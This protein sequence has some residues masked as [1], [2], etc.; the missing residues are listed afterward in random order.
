MR[1]RCRGAMLL[2]ARAALLALLLTL[3]GP[4]PAEA[5]ASLSATS[6]A[7][8]EFVSDEYF[9]STQLTI[10]N[11][12]TPV[13]YFEDQNVGGNVFFDRVEV[14]RRSDSDSELIF[15]VEESPDAS[16]YEVCYSW[17]TCSKVSVGVNA[18]NGLLFLSSDGPLKN[19][20]YV[21]DF[22]SQR[23]E[24]S[25]QEA[26]G[27]RKVYREVMVHRSQRVADCSDY[28][29]Q[30]KTRYTC[31]FLKEQVPPVPLSTT[32]S[33]REAL[34]EDL[35]QPKENYSLMFAEE[36]N[37]TAAVHSSGRCRNRM[38]TLNQDYLIWN[39]GTNPCSRV[40]SLGVPCNDIEDG[41]YYMALSW[42]C[43]TNLGTEGN[44]NYKYGYIEI[45]YTI[46]YDAWSDYMNLALSVGNPTLPLRNQYRRYGIEQDNYESILKTL[47]GVVNFFEYLPGSRIEVMHSW[48]NPYGTIRLRNT[49]PVR[50]NTFV[51]YCSAYHNPALRP[52]PSGFC[53]TGGS[54]TVTKGMEWTPSGYRF[55]IK[56]HGVHDDF[57][58]F[59][60]S[61]LEVQRKPP[62][63]EP[64]GRI[65]FGTWR[66]LAGEEHSSFFEHLQ[67][68]DADDVLV[69]VGVSHIPMDITLAAWGNPTPVN[70]R[71]KTKLATDYIRVYQPTN[72]YRDMEPTF[73]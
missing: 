48:V 33:M 63:E 37:G 25:L 6:A 7:E 46:L 31:L 24:L 42:T 17:P 28:P 23:V 69:Q 44:F 59:A 27:A 72:G 18:N 45:K 36:F 5:A 2:T 13:P 12:G 61:D 34:P 41:H 71:I 43:L 60:D 38:D 67:E 3:S 51:E 21:N 55:L 22:P 11:N 14:S 39:Y 56:V 30:D 10:F 16:P 26:D 35:A 62:S 8:L 9:L 68:G 73:Q 49:P 58:V 52:R 29:Y 53:R 4:V 47:G 70:S 57:V 15:A 20:Y 50:T 54:V 32:A 1:Q 40:D 64:G 19:D 65:T 66:T